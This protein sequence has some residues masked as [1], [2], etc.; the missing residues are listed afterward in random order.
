MSG[1]L[2]GRRQC[3]RSFF[4]FREQL[5]QLA[6]LPDR[7]DASHLSRSCA[8]QRQ[9]IWQEEER[10]LAYFSTAATRF[11]QM[12]VLICGGQGYSPLFRPDLQKRQPGGK[13]KGEASRKRK[14]IQTKPRRPVLKNWGLIFFKNDSPGRE[15]KGEAS[16]ERKKRPNQAA[17]A[18]FEEFEPRFLQKRQSREGKGKEKLPGKGKASKPSRGGRF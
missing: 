14:S 17:A 18:G 5:C 13:R 15:R 4:R 3:P 6:V 11:D 8:Q 16:R 9:N 7:N 10:F 1:A 2:A 12:V